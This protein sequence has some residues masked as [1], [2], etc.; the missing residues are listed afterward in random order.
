MAEAVL[1]PAVS[2]TVAA[3]AGTGKT[4]LLTSRIVRLL[5]AGAN[6]AG[7]VAL[8]F[9]RKAAAEMRLRVNEALRE[10]AESGSE[11]QDRILEGIGLVPDAALKQKSRQ[12]YREQL[13][14][15]FAM[16]ASTLHAF[17]Q[18]LVGRFA[19]EAGVTPGFKLVEEEAALQHRAW[20]RVQTHILRQPESAAARALTT[21]MDLGETEHGVHRQV[22]D[23]L[24]RR[25]DWRAFVQGQPDP[26]LYA[27]QRWRA[28]LAELPDAQPE[29]PKAFNAKL[30]ILLRHLQTMGGTR[31]LK[32]EKLAPALELDRASAAPRTGAGSADAKR[33]ALQD[34]RWR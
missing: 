19:F 34:R 4:W 10:L 32:P 3:S 28:Q 17:C 8:T 29:A 6:P 5:L 13:F 24:Q 18:E 33:H 1:N 31:W 14:Q 12:L 11:A 23:F 25:N 30:C 27:H 9:T 7:I 21:L 16:R 15:P 20:R 26:V 22:M 2:A